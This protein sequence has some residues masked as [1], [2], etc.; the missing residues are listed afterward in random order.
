MGNEGL[1][2]WKT[3]EAMI[4][5]PDNN[6]RLRLA[7]DAECLWNTTPKGY[8]EDIDR[9]VFNSHVQHAIQRFLEKPENRA[10]LMELILRMDNGGQLVQ[11]GNQQ[12]EIGDRN[13]N[14]S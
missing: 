12:K 1:V 14:S 5:S 8:Q 4:S 9:K 11:P 10:A 7:I 13:E 2:N 3:I 6:F